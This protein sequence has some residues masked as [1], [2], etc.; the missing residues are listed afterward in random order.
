MARNIPGTPHNAF[1]A[2]TT[3]IEKSA[4]IFTFEATI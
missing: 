4:F 3:I 2:R 1:P